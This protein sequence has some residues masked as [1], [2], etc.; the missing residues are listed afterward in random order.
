[1]I[2]AKGSIHRKNGQRPAA[3]WFFA[4]VATTM[5]IIVLIAFS[6]TFFFRP[7]SSVMDLSATLGQQTLPWYLVV[8]GTV[9][10]AWYALFC[11]QTWLAVF[12]KIGWHRRLGAIGIG[13]SAAVTVSAISTTIL[14]VPRA[15]ESGRPI[16]NVTKVVV[17]N[18]LLQASFVLCVSLAVYWRRW[19]DLHKRLMYYAA[20]AS[21]KPAFAAGDRVFGAFLERLLPAV[22]ASN[23]FFIAVAVCVGALALFDWVTDRR[24]R[25]V[26]VVPG[27]LLLTD[28]IV[29]MNS[30]ST[31]WGQHLVNWLS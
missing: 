2:D 18:L 20:I 31:S 8:H 3:K 25:P 5:L 4:V 23:R 30:D 22:I 11:A 19:P 7:L 24:T 27:L 26:T 6:R 14:F 28:E 9:L 1:M 15:L 13:I 21:I 16:E 17:G 10:T 12:R 29:A